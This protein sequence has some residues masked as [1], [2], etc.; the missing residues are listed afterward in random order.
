ML[1]YYLYFILSLFI[2]SLII[3]FYKS[4]KL[5]ISNRIK[6]VY[7]TLILNFKNIPLIISFKI[8]IFRL[9]FS[10]I[11]NKEIFKSGVFIYSNRDIYKDNRN[12]INK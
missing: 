5:N 9:L 4:G 7:F 1:N 11:D 6:I 12:R 2:V 3:Y 10:T 8:T